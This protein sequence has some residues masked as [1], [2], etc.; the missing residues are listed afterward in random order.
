MRLT[1]PKQFYLS[2]KDIGKPRASSCANKLRELNQYVRIS[3]H[4][5]PVD[6]KFL[7]QFK[8]P[9]FSHFFFWVYLELK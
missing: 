4:N 5:G 1:M 8:V 9:F 2:E 3:V 6:E 7:T